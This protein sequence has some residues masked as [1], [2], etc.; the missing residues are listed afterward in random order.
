VQDDE[1]LSRKPDDGYRQHEQDELDGE[2]DDKRE[3]EQDDEYY[4]DQDDK[5]DDNQDDKQDDNQDDKQDDDQDDK[6]DKYDKHGERY[7]RE[8]LQTGRYYDDDDDLM[9][10]D[11]NQGE[12]AQADNERI[13]P[14]VFDV[15]ERH[16]AKNGRRK[17]PSPSRLSTVTFF[18]HT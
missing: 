17:A 11:R 2:H 4:D 15:L 7:P 10:S 3:D 14:D 13:D 8:D 16:Q 18:F 9:E 5:Q 12:D 1:D 6:Q